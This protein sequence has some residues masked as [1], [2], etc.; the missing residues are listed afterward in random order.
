M[1]P[2]RLHSDT[3]FSINS[4]VFGSAIRGESFLEP[5]PAVKGPQAPFGDSARESPI[6]VGGCGRRFFEWRRAFCS[7]S[8]FHSHTR[9]L[10]NARS[11]TPLPRPWLYPL[12]A[13][14]STVPGPTQ[15]ASSGIRGRLTLRS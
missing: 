11:C 5:L 8:G 9:W 10:T 7:V 1:N 15:H 12:V 14:P 13:P 4:L 2:R 6:L 3:I